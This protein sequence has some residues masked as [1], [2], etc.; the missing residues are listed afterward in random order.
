MTRKEL[1]AKMLKNEPVEIFPLECMWN[2]QTQ[3]MKIVGE[4]WE[5]KM[6]IKE[7]DINP[8]HI[9]IL[10]MEP[11]KAM[12]LCKDQ[13]GRYIFSHK[14]YSMLCKKRLEIGKIYDAEITSV[15][16]WGVFCNVEDAN[17]LVHVKEISGCR[18]FELK[19]AF[20]V[21]DKFPVKILAKEENEYGLHVTA[22]RKQAGSDVDYKCGDIVSVIVA[23]KLPVGCAVFCEVTP[24]VNGIV[25]VSEKQLKQ[26]NEGD[27]I[28]VV[29]RSRTEKGYKFSGMYTAIKK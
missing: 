24:S 18:F 12:V 3:T 19:R 20:K 29:V 2:N 9:M 4:D 26:L 1:E 10:F 28:P 22:S 11:F 21:G 14:M 6:S 8:K 16:D 23:S 7:I 27:K 25:N 5:G 15:C 17:V 13:E